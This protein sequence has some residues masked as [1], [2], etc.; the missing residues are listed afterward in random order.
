MGE[1]IKHT[2]NELKERWVQ[3]MPRFFRMIVKI[4]TAIALTATTV[5]FGVPALG[6]VLY[7]WWPGVYTN[8]LVGSICTV[9]VCKVTVAGGYKELDPDE[10]LRGKRHIQLTH[11]IDEQIDGEQPGN[12]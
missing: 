4:V 10:L 8:I 6:G 12:E 2:G 5:N 11:D 7:E 9:M 1:Q 3:R